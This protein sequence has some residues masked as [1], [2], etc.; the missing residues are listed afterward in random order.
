[1]L[2][3]PGHFWKTR[4]ICLEVTGPSQHYLSTRAR[5]PLCFV[6]AWQVRTTMW[7]DDAIRILTPAP[8]AS[9][10]DRA[11]VRALEPQWLLHLAGQLAE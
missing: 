5:R 10:L 3:V 1:M 7:A 4:S 11:K 6:V 2:A 9:E 8:S